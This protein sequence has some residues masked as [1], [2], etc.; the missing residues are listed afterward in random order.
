MVAPP[1]ITV[2]IRAFSRGDSNSQVHKTVRDTGLGY[3][4]HQLRRTPVVTH[5][6]YIHNA[7]KKFSAAE[8]RVPS[9]MMLF[10][11]FSS[12]F[13]F[14]GIVLPSIM[15]PLEYLKTKV[16]MNDDQRGASPS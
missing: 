16:A 8:V 10:S 15:G 3:V 6:L 9:L 5:D 1:D 14:C 7:S 2:G 12:F 4:Y 11:S 13:R